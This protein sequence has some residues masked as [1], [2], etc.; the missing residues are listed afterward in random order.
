MV[1]RT[2]FVL[3][4]VKDGLTGGGIYWGAKGWH[5]NRKFAWRIP[6]QAAW[7]ALAKNRADAEDSKDAPLWD[8]AILC[9]LVRRKSV[10]HLSFVP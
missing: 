6:T 9:H 4:K 7:D 5:P 3:F 10:D 2:G 8:N 1:N